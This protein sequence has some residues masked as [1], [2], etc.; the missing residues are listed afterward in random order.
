[1]IR[2]QKMPSMANCH[3]L[4]NFS[5]PCLMTMKIRHPPPVEQGQTN[6][7]KGS[8]LEFPDDRKIKE[9]T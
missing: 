6:V 8:P 2:S 9:A 4:E 7:A 3:Y 5:N 1:M